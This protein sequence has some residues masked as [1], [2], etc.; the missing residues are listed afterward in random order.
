MKSIRAKLAEVFRSRLTRTGLAIT[1]AAAALLAPRAVLAQDANP[2]NDSGSFIIRILPSV[3]LG[4]IVDTTGAHWT[5]SAD[6]DMAADMDT[7][8]LLETGVQ[9]TVVGNFNNQELELSAAANDTWALDTDEAPAVDQLRLYAV[10]GADQAAPPAAVNS[11]GAG[12]L[13]TASPTR[14]GQPQADELTDNNHT[15]EFST[16][17]SPQYEDVDGM[18]VGTTRRLWLRADTPPLTTSD[19]QQTFTVTVTAVTGAGF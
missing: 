1:L 2:A 18:T 11:S 15:Y 7:T 19:E 10:V 14:A 4:V 9:L 12:N 16:A 6:L 17:Q 5:G 8:T 13:V 3:D